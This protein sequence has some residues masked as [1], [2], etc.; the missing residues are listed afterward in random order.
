MIFQHIVPTEMK[1]GE[2]VH[3]SDQLEDFSD[4]VVEDIFEYQDPDIAENEQASGLLIKGSILTALAM[5]H[6]LVAMIDPDE[7]NTLYAA[8]ILESVVKFGYTFINEEENDIPPTGRLPYGIDDIIIGRS[9]LTIVIDPPEENVDITKDDSEIFNDHYNPDDTTT[10]IGLHA[11]DAGEFEIVIS[12]GGF[13]NTGTSLCIGPCGVR[14]ISFEIGED[15]HVNF[16]CDENTETEEQEELET[17]LKDE[18]GYTD[19]DI[20]NSIVVRGAHLGF[21]NCD[22]AELAVILETGGEIIYTRYSIWGIRKNV[23]NN[24]T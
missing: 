2:I 5:D 19:D 17:F 8:N 6:Y 20:F 3:L 11:C 21:R 12:D 24:R 15:W 18:V 9:I 7:L 23:P 16:P 22:D 14:Q 13:T 1:V 10:Q 4:G